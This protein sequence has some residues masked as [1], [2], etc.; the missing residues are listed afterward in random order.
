M[1]KWRDKHCH[2]VHP[3]NLP[4]SQ[5]TCPLFL[6]LS[7]LILFYVDLGQL[8]GERYINFNYVEET[9]ILNFGLSLEVFSLFYFV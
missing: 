2:C 1:I 8:V 4:P 9:V 6:K 5:H 7:E 3:L